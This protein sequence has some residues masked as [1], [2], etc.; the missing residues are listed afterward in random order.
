MGMILVWPILKRMGKRDAALCGT[1][2]VVIGQAIMHV[3]PRSFTVILIGTILKGFG[4][5]PLR[6]TL[7]AMAADKIEYGEWKSGVRNEGLTCGVLALVT[8]IT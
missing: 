8:K 7:F 3:A 5:A 6:G 4:F 1:G 2:V